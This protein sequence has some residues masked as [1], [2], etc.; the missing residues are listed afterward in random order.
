MRGHGDAA[1]QKSSD[2]GWQSEQRTKKIAD[3]RGLVEQYR[4]RKVKAYRRQRTSIQAPV[5]A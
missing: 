2:R 4:P 5:I 3:R 1:R